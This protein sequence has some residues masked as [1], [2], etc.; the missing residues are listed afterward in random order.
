MASLLIAAPRYIPA[1]TEA[2]RWNTPEHQ[3]HFRWLGRELAIAVGRTT[4]L[5]GPGLGVRRGGEPQVR[6][7]AGRA[8]PRL[9]RS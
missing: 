1:W 7:T 4:L 9:C 8:G 5:V 2:R 6:P 3:E